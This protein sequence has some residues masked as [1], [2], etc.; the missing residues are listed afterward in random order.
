MR[1]RIAGTIPLDSSM[2]FEDLASKAK[3]DE[4]FLT[5]VLRHAI[6]YHI[7]CDPSPSHV[8]HIISSL[9]LHSS[10]SVRDWLEMKLEEWGPASVNAINVLAEYSGSQ[11]PRETGSDMTLNDQTSF[12]FLAERPER[13]NVFG[14]AVG[15][16]SKGISHKVEHLVENYDWEGLGHGTVVD[17]SH[18]FQLFP[19]S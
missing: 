19:A 12:E 4:A 5:R 13:A 8:S 3:L 14:S 15:N 6:I 11:E 16:F 17:V 7:F 10:N 9:S 1:Y 2:T 18:T